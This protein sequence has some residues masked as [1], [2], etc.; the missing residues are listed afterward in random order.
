MTRTLAALALFLCLSLP[1]AQARLGG[2]GPLQGAAF[3]VTGAGKVYFPFGLAVPSDPYLNAKVGML[4]KSATFTFTDTNGN[5]ES[6]VTLTGQ[7]TFTWKFLAQPF[8]FDLPVV[9]QGQRHGKQFH[10]SSGDGTVTLRGTVLLV[11]NEG[12]VKDIAKSFVASGTASVSGQVAASAAGPLM[13]DFKILGKRL[14][15]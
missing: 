14:V 1:L 5:Y 9:L 13:F 11:K 7:F 15:L 2:G 8:Q 3:S 12:G 10:V 4:V 6:D